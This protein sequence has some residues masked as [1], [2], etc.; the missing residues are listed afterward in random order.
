MLPVAINDKVL[1][2]SFWELY[3]LCLKNLFLNYFTDKDMFLIHLMV[4][5]PLEAQSRQLHT[6]NKGKPQ[7]WLKKKYLKVR[8]KS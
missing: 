4:P 6:Q 1:R 8:G 3:H 2:G 7:L 5:F